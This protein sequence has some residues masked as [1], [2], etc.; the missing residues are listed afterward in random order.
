METYD[1]ETFCMC[2]QLLRAGAASKCIHFEFCT[3]LYINVSTTTVQFTLI[4]NK[5]YS[6][7]Q[8]VAHFSPKLK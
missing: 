7:K 6:I 2:A 4:C 3:I 5:I 1:V 8:K